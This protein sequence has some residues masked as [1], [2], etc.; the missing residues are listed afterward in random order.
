[1]LDNNFL[2]RA[3]KAT[4]TTQKDLMSVFGVKNQSNVCSMLQHELR[5]SDYEKALNA[6]GLE[7][8]VIKRQ[9]DTDGS[10]TAFEIAYPEE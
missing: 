8:M 2:K 6:M 10:L 9:Y 5:I 4:K 3:M 1:M 7:L